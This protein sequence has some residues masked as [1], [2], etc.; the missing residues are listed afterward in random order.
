MRGDDDDVVTLLDA[1]VTVW[2]DDFIFSNDAGD[3]AIGL[4]GE[5]LQR[6]IV[7]LFGLFREKFQR[8]YAAFH[9]AV[10]CQHVTAG[11]NAY[12]SRLFFEEKGIS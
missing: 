4:D 11:D 3:E 2:D 5:I 10:K 6:P 8:L 7:K 1:G 12:F 9:D